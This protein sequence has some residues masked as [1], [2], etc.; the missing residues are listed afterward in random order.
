MYRYSLGNRRWQFATLAEL[1]AKA[2]PARSGDR[3]AGVIA[4]AEATGELVR[5][6]APEA[7]SDEG[8]WPCP[9]CTGDNG[10]DDD[11]GRQHRGGVPYVHLDFCT[12]AND[13]LSREVVDAR[14]EREA[15]SEAAR[16]ARGR[17][18]RIGIVDGMTRRIRS[19]DARGWTRAALGDAASANISSAKECERVREGPLDLLALGLRG[20]TLAR[21]V[22]TS[23]RIS[24]GRNLSLR[25]RPASQLPSHV[26]VVFWERSTPRSS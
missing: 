13:G 22:V 9:L 20:G 2:T 10:A 15:R 6:T 3:L 12:T 4:H 5:I 18:P 11:A 26:A 23:R 25:A 17:A 7:E 21:E 24:G 1:M 8:G 19:I 16:L 14:A